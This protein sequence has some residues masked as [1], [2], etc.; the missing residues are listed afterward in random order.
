MRRAPC[1]GSTRL[2]SLASTSTRE[3]GWMSVQ[4]AC[5]VCVVSA[6]VWRG[7]REGGHARATSIASSVAAGERAGCTMH[8]EPR[9]SCA[10]TLQN[11]RVRQLP[12]LP[13]YYSAFLCGNCGICGKC[14]KQCAWAEGVTILLLSFLGFKIP[15]Q[16]SPSS[17]LR[18]TTYVSES[19]ST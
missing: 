7:C 13:F 6:R 11:G 3:P 19:K 15:R 16:Q 18:A 14:G 4:C 9:G 10:L 2:S 5:Q 12:K 8:H 17:Y 1:A